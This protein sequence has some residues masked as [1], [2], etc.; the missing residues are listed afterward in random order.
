MASCAMDLPDYSSTGMQLALTTL[1][2]CREWYTSGMNTNTPDT[3][4]ASARR[5]LATEAEAIIALSAQIDES[6]Q[7]A[8]AL[9]LA[10]PGRLIITGMGKSG[11]IANKIAATMASTGTPAFF[12]HPA[13]AAHG[14]LGM[15]TRQDVVLALSNSGESDEIIALLP[16]LSRLGVPL[17]TMTGNRESTMAR[18]SRVHLYAGVA[19]EACPLNLAPTASTTAALALGDALAVVLL[20]QRGFGSEDFAMSHPGGSLGRRLLVHVRDLMHAGDLLPQVSESVL[21]KDAL[22]EMS[23][24]GL[25]MTAVVDADGGLAGV[26]TDGDLRRTLDKDVDVRTALVRDV[27]TRNPATIDAGKLA[28]EAAQVMEAKR[29]NGLLVLDGSKLVGAINMHD[30]MRARVV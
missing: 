17:I 6:F 3:I 11:H 7:A 13:E 15:I 25:G 20:E 4:L 5:V 28:A 12:V 14:D 26:F 16:S 24:K 29:I 18:E 27:M 19:Q 10:C 2:D 1:A 9:I 30:L 23:R 22:L 8:C 21:L